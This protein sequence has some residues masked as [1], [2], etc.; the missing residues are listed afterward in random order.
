MER[1]RENLK[2]WHNWYNCLT[3]AF[4]G[5][6]TS[7]WRHAGKRR[8]QDARVAFVQVAHHALFSNCDCNCTEILTALTTPC[9]TLLM[10]LVAPVSE[11]DAAT[12]Q[13][14]RR[15]MS[16]R[17]CSY[18]ACALQACR[19]RAWG[20]AYSCVARAHRPRFYRGQDCPSEW[21]WQHPIAM[22]S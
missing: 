2:M 15:L 6:A 5:Y 12:L 21:L 9:A 16:S 7:S 3:R 17:R 11:K 14:L 19:H 1:R 10:T 8:A 18:E 13:E 20:T 22:S 4:Y